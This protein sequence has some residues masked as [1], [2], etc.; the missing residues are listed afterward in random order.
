MEDKTCLIEQ[1]DIFDF[2]A[3]HVGLTVIHPGGFDATRKLLGSCHIDKSSKILDI[4]CGKGTTSI[5]LAQEYGCKVVGL[6]LSEDLLSQATTLVKRKGLEHKVSFRVGN[7]LNMPITK[8]FLD[9]VSNVICA[10]CMLGV[11]TF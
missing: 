4:G 5:L 10:Y 2:M 11:E 9:G 1:C 3:N 8:E 6:D 7:A